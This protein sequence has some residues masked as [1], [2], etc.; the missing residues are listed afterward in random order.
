MT[1]TPCRRRIS[2]QGEVQEMRDAVGLKPGSPGIDILCPQDVVFGQEELLVNLFKVLLHVPLEL[3]ILD[4]G[5]HRV[6]EVSNPVGNAEGP[7][8]HGRQEPCLGKFLV[9]LEEEF[10]LVP[11]IFEHRSKGLGEILDLIACLNRHD[12]V[13]LVLL[14]ILCIPGQFGDRL[15]DRSSGGN[16]REKGRGRR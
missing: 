3:N 13:R 12:L 4:P 7:F 2:L 14:D 1:L 8:P 6:Q 5:L 11:E 9:G 10:L 16:R 15:Q